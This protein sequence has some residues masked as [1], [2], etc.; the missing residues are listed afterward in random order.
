DPLHQLVASMHPYPMSAGQ[1]SPNPCNYDDLA[2]L[3]AHLN[4]VLSTMPVVA[5]EFG[6]D[7]CTADSVEN[8]L[9]FLDGVGVG[10]LAWVWTTTHYA[11]PGP[12]KWDLITDYS[13]GAPTVVGAAVQQHYRGL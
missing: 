6:R 4:P 10:Y 3:Q 8:L 7:D 13:S 11:C 2:C 1:G 5:G 9:H 12:N